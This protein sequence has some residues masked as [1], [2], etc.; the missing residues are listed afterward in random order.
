MAWWYESQCRR[1]NCVSGYKKRIESLMRKI[2]PE[3]LTVNQIRYLILEKRR[4]VRGVRLEQF[5]RTGRVIPYVGELV[6]C[7][8]GT[9]FKRTKVKD[10]KVSQHPGL[11]RLLFGMEFLAIIGLI[12][13]VNHWLIGIAYF[14]F[15][16]ESCCRSSATHVGADPDG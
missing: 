2:Y 8:N 14:N 11:D 3:D 16:S 4:A 15:K 13:I 7:R 5:Q 10:D 6:D 12:S 9:S 1:E